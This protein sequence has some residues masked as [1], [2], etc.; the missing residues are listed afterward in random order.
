MNILQQ[1]GIIPIDFSAMEAV[2]SGYR[3]PKDKVSQM[4]KNRGLISHK[5]GIFVVLRDIHRLPMRILISKLSANACPVCREDARVDFS[6]LKK[7]RT[8]MRLVRF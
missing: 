7:Q 1:F 2:L 3:H 4:E 6:K 8:R 5:K